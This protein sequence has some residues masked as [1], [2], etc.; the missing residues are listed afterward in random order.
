MIKLKD[1][2][3]EGGA[4]IFGR[5]KYWTVK[6]KFKFDTTTGDY[7][8]TG[9]H[10]G[11]HG[12][13]SQELQKAVMKTIVAEPGNPKNPNQICNYPGGLFYIDNKKK[14][15]YYMSKDNLK[16]STRDVEP[17]FEKVTD[18]SL[19]KNWK[20]YKDGIGR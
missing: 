1:L 15:A 3:K 17:R 4:R 5:Q 8:G 9:Q 13:G 19:W 20:P 6:K 11:G 12:R 18:F 14:K 16:V 10:Y 7:K 2:L